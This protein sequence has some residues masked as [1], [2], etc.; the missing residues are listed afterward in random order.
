MGRFTKTVSLLLVV[1]LGGATATAC[2][3]ACDNR[4]PAPVAQANLSCHQKAQDAAAPLA[5]PGWGQ[6]SKTCPILEAFEAREHFLPVAPASAS[7][8]AGPALPAHPVLV[9]ELPARNLSLA[10]PSLPPPALPIY[11]QRAVLR[12]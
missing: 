4:E 12:L 5:G 1:A 9:A 10:A 6:V 2:A 11:L 3:F 7:A 8:L